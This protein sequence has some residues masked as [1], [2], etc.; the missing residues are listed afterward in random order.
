MATRIKAE[1]AAAGT[2]PKV[3]AMKPGKVAR[4]EKSNDFMGAQRVTTFKPNGQT[5][6]EAA[7]DP[8]APDP[9]AILLPTPEDA[10]RL[11]GELAAMND[12]AK[13]AEHKFSVL[14]DAAK[15]AKETYDELAAKVLSRLQQGT[16]KSNLPLFVDIEQREQDQAAMEAGGSEAASDPIENEPQ[17]TQ[18][19]RGGTDEGEIP[20]SVVGS[21][22]DEQV[23]MVA[24]EDIPF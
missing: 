17:G 11:L 16:H 23:G 8:D 6:V 7:P 2:T 1:K 22:S 10:V 14:R 13:E 12:R 9:G 5:S 3:R 21:L 19:E 18:D 20:P 15:S 24:D 4:A